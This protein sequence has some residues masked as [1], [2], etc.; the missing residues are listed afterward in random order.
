MKQYQQF[1]RTIREDGV[2]RE[3]RTGVGT[4]SIFGYQNRYNLFEG[5]PAVTTK[6][7]F[8]KGV[9]GELL[10]FI[11]GDTN[12][13]WLQENGIQFWNDWAREDGDLGPIYG[14][15]LRQS[16]RYTADGQLQ[17]IDQLAKAI[18]S[19]KATPYSRR[20]VIS[21][22]NPH[23]IEAS[24]LP[25]CHGTVIQFYVTP[26][27]ECPVGCWDGMVLSKGCLC[28]RC[29]D[30]PCTVCNG[31]GIVGPRLSCHM[32]QRSADSFLGVPVNIASYSLLT[33]MIAQV[34]GLGVGEF[35][36]SFGDAHI[37]ANHLEQV[38]ELLTRK[39]LPLPTLE[40]DPSI[41]NIDDFDFE[42][43]KLV[44]YQHHPH[45]PAPI[46]V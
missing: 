42:H 7:L 19:I 29:Y 34:C 44:N 33:H 11:R 17:T 22:W 36:H 15:Q 23:D 10:W 25:P 39:P 40:L 14:K 41:K 43:I 9:V 18:E 30:D 46:A 38:D 2:Y 28:M 6:K 27:G 26:E 4:Y 20:H 3:D 12:V 32:Y 24:A 16:Q 5:F 45:I 31:T 37:Y 13:K 8:W 35:I 21:L 1:L